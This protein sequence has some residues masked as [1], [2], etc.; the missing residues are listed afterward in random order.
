MS[1]V[2]VGVV[3]SNST[4]AGSSLFCMELTS[5]SRVWELQT[6]V[7]F[8]EAFHLLNGFASASMTSLTDTCPYLKLKAILTNKISLH[9]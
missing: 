8:C 1:T 4:S 5:I 3:V 6:I 9:C 2:S 7:R